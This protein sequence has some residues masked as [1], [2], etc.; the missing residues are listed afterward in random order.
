VRGGPLSVLKIPFRVFPSDGAPSTSTSVAPEIHRIWDHRESARCKNRRFNWRDKAGY[1]TKGEGEFAVV[2]LGHYI[3]LDGSDEAVGAC[4]GQRQVRSTSTTEPDGTGVYARRH[5]EA[6][7]AVTLLFSNEAPMKF[8]H[9]DW[10]PQTRWGYRL[11]TRLHSSSDAELKDR[12]KRYWPTE[13]MIAFATKLALIRAIQHRFNED[14]AKFSDELVKKDAEIQQCLPKHKALRLEDS[15]LA[16]RLVAGIDAFI[17][18]SRS[19]YEILGVVVKEIVG[20]ILGK[21]MNERSLREVL[22]TKGHDTTWI[23]DL[24]DERARSFIGRHPGL[25]LRSP[26]MTLHTKF[27]FFDETPTI[28]NQTLA[29]RFHLA[30]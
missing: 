18:E 23:D 19:A 1:H 2:S 24:H 8:F 13:Q 21:K 27:A 15:E 4:N 9:I 3:I 28:W 25:P 20:N 29:P 12:F 5:L 10:L 11:V 30:C 6:V 14:V 26:R 7:R 22:E 17:F 16:F